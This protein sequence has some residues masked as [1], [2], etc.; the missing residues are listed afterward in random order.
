MTLS[1]LLAANESIK[2]QLNKSEAEIVAKIAALQAA[3]DTLTESVTMRCTQ[4]VLQAAVDTLT[5]SLA[6]VEL[7]E[8]QAQSV[9]D[10]QAAVQALEALD[11]EIAKLD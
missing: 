9:T 10:L 7:T 2:N 3:V 8:E 1:E 11:Q 4:S 6:D 5:A